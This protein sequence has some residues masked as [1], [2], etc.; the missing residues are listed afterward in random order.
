[1]YVTVREPLGTTPAAA[2][3]EREYVTLKP[4]AL[5]ATIP[6]TTSWAVVLS[7]TAPAL[8][9]PTG[10]ASDTDSVTPEAVLLSICAVILRF[11]SLV[12]IA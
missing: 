3:A 2:V 7:C 5:P 4:L 1:V 9:P 11:D 10:A 12:V 8:L 6:V